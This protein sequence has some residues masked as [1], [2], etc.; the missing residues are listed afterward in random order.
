MYLGHPSSQNKENW[1]RIH[2]NILSFN[3]NQLAYKE[4]LPNYCICRTN[5]VS[6]R[7]L[8][9]RGRFEVL[10]LWSGG[11]MGIMLWKVSI[12]HCLELQ[13]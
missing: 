1:L 12:P 2:N 8:E 13:N 5:N 9:M 3:K 10:K 4:N 11:L 6:V 7:P